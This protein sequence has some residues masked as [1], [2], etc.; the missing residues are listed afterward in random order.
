MESTES[1]NIGRAIQEV[2]DVYTEV[3]SE[4][5]RPNT[6]DVEAARAAIMERN[7]PSGMSIQ[8]IRHLLEWCWAH[9]N[10]KLAQAAGYKAYICGLIPDILER[11]ELLFTRWTDVWPHA[12]HWNK[13]QERQYHQGEQGLP[14]SMQLINLWADRPNN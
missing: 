9:R 6:R 5:Y 7:L 11:M 13:P 8:T 3:R 4:L 14:E 12:K 2:V 10:V 1:S